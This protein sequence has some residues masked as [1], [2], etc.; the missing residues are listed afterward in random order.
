VNNLRVKR[1]NQPPYGGLWALN[2]PDKGLVGTGYVY[3]ALRRNLAEY[4]KANDIPIGIGFD[5]EIEQSLCAQYPGE[6]GDESKVRP[7]RLEFGDVVNGAKVMLALKLSG[8]QLVPAAEAE[9][10]AAI[11]GACPHNEDFNKP[12]AGIC[13]KLKELVHKIIGA[14]RTKLDDD[15][16]AC[17]ICSC[18]TSAHIWLPVE[19]LN[20]GLTDLMRDRFREAKEKHNCWKVTT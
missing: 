17:K 15:N 20:K 14:N 16:K 4:R 19:I 11:C 13:Q 8:S 2:L 10:R 7:H 6:C 18:F 1:R 12:C 9:R 5:D 3:E